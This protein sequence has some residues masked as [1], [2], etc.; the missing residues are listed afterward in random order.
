MGVDAAGTPSSILALLAMVGSPAH[1]ASA[2]MAHFRALAQDL[3]LLRG[4]MEAEQYLNNSCTKW[5]GPARE[6]I[7][8][9]VVLYRIATDALGDT[10][11]FNLFND[12]MSARLC[13]LRAVGTRRNAHTLTCHIPTEILIDH[14][15]RPYFDLNNPVPE[16]K[17]THSA[18]ESPPSPTSA[19]TGA[20]SHTSIRACGPTPCC[21]CG[22]HGP[23]AH[24]TSPRHRPSSSR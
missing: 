12:E 21:T 14:Y 19:A 9:L 3:W 24:L 6:R 10:A 23:S 16:D 22:A 7:E 15:Q 5:R 8:T 4:E 20:P 11:A 17:G 2:G 18:R 13:V 1:R